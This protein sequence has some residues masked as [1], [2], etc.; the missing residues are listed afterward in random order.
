M[1]YL[2]VRLFLGEMV[3]EVGIELEPFASVRPAGEILIL[4]EV[5]A[6]DQSAISLRGGWWTR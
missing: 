4:N 6:N 1:R 5:K 3:D 2:A